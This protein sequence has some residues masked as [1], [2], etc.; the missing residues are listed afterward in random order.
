MLPH[1]SSFVLLFLLLNKTV[2]RFLKFK[3]MSIERYKELKMSLLRVI[4]HFVQMRLIIFS[5][6]KTRSVSRPDV[7]KGD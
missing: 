2:C 6:E 1:L 7:V 3:V 5:F 4:P